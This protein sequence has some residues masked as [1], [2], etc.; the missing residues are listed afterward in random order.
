MS[1]SVMKVGGSCLTGIDSISQLSK[2]SNMW[3]SSV[4]VVSAFKGVTD[5]LFDAYYG[6]YRVEYVERLI[7]G[8]SKDLHKMNFGTEDFIF[9]KILALMRF[10]SVEDFRKKVSECNIDFYVSLG[11][12]ISG[13]ICTIYLEDH[14]DVIYLDS[15]DTGIFIKPVGGVN[16][17]DLDMSL[18]L[19]SEKLKKYLGNR[20]IITTGF[21][22][23]DQSGKITIAGR[24]SSDYVASVLAVK[25]MADRL[26]LF[27]D[28]DGIY[29]ADPKLISAISPISELNY[30]QAI[31]Y[32]ID[33]G[34]I[35]PDA[36]RICE[37][38]KIIIHV[39][40]YST[41]KI[42]TV[43]KPFIDGKTDLFFPETS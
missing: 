25:L 43:V 33:G 10:S 22:G 20:T 12:Q 3:P 4:I 24:N 32:S 40:S 21:Y 13:A 5:A 15:I 42:G 26:V 39:T 37:E 31:K 38:N 7:R 30:E 16:K 11:E 1:F 28:V 8:Y 2:I 14:C 6:L 29:R 19:Y 34:I 35:H 23:L 17:I 27:K 9:E 36:V 41:L 18:H